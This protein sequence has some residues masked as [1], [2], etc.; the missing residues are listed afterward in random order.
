LTQYQVE[1]SKATLNVLKANEESLRQGVFLEVQQAYLN[2]QD[3]EERI[4]TAE[5][6]VRQTEENLDIA[7][8]RYAA[9]VGNPIEV[10]DAQVAY[11][12][13]KTSYIQA[14]YDYKVAQASLEKAMGV[15]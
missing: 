1:E 6:A 8:G 9:G 11:T 7:N 5:L 13:A 12:N 2:L 10:T 15:K 3:A 14:L 4:P